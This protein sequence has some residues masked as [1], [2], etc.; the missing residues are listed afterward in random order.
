MPSGTVNPDM[1][2]HKHDKEG[3]G[4]GWSPHDAG[5]LVTGSE[6]TTVKLWCVYTDH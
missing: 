2:L 3:F 4:L 1:E 5:H 6:D